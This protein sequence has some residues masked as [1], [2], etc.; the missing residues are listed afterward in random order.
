MQ[1]FHCYDNIDA[2]CE[3]SASAP[4]LAVW[5]VT[6]ASVKCCYSNCV[7]RTPTRSASNV[8]LHRPQDGTPNHFKILLSQHQTLDKEGTYLTVTLS[9]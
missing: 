6:V 9:S 7:N 8:H 3:M 1:A 4:V 5:P 2:Y